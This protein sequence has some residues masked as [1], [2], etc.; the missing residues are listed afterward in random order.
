[1]RAILP[2]SFLKEG[3]SSIPSD[4]LSF[5][6][7]YIRA[8][9]KDK[10]VIVRERLNHI[11]THDATFKNLK[12]EKKGNNILADVVLR[13]T[14]TSSIH[15]QRTHYSKRPEINFVRRISTPLSCLKKSTNRER[16]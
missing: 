12:H 1:M 14:V 16:G 7:Q 5:V 8:Q 15:K 2:P 9:I 13:R 3:V 6:A 4:L 11:L 10:V